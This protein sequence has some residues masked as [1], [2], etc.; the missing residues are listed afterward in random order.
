MK[1]TTMI[2]PRTLIGQI[3]TVRHIDVSFGITGRLRYD[4]D[5]ERYS[6]HQS[7]KT[8]NAYISFSHEE[9]VDC[10]DSTITIL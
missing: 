2:D 1:E 10:E 3:A 5:A 6:I 9:I 4:S 8:G 7:W